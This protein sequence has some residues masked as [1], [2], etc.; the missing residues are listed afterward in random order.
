MLPS[1]HVNYLKSIRDLNP[2]VVYDI[3]SC[4]LDWTNEARKIWPDAKFVL[5][6]AFDL[7][8]SLYVKE[9]YEDYHIGVLSDSDERTVKFYQNDTLCTGNSYYKELNDSV[10]PPDRYILKKTRALD[11][12]VKEKGFSLPDLIK[13]DVQ[14][15][16]LDVINGASECLGHAKHLIVELQ[17]VQYNEG[18]PKVD[19]SLPYIESLG[20]K[21]V[22]PLFSNNG[23]DGDY[24]FI[25][26][27]SDELK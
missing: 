10:F 22:A 18:A 25:K 12:V 9:G 3:G 26:K 11:S 7:A 27:K 13:I 14:G 4:V 23:P 15:S 8:E 5:F 16:E 17:S 6:D 20:W 2:R 1:D 19:V 24:G 21:C